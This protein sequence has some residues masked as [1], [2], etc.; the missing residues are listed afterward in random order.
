MVS[1]VRLEKA[2]LGVVRLG[3]NIADFRK[4]KYFFFRTPRLGLTIRAQHYLT[5]H[6]ITIGR[7]FMRE[8]FLQAKNRQSE[9][10]QLIIK[11]GSVK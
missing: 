10:R 1:V 7:D 9:L 6:W 3:T 8:I 4:R 2:K 11:I 5:L